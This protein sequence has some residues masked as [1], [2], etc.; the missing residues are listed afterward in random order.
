MQDST[1][2]QQTGPFD[3]A[4]QRINEASFARQQAENNAG[5][6]ANARAVKSNASTA[7]NNIGLPRF[8]TSKGRG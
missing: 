8:R 1:P 2:S 3:A 5:Q 4:Q 7:A 6:A